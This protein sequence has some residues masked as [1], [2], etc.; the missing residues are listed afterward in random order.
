LQLEELPGR[1]VRLKN[2]S[3]KERVALPDGSALAPGISGEVALPLSLVIGYTE[4]TIEIAPGG[5]EAQG[6]GKQASAASPGTEPEHPSR[7]PSGGQPRQPP[8]ANAALSSLGESPP[9]EKFT[10]WL[11]TVLS[12]QRA[13]TGS[14]EFYDQTAQAL[15][16]LV[17][18]DRGLVLLRRGR[19][20]E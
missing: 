20:W 18:L 11:E 13:P 2:L 10:S 9:P 17:G 6:R 19:L 12:L 15:V 14:R 4:V 5:V 3:S 1:R 16:G 8:P 7:P